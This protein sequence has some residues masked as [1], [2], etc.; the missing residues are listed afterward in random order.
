MKDI[1]RL[2]IKAKKIYVP[3]KEKLI[4]VMIGY[5]KK[6]NIS[7]MIDNG[8]K[9]QTRYI[10]FDCDT[11]EEAIT[12]VEQIVNEYPNDKDTGMADF[13]RDINASFD[14]GGL[15]V[16]DRRNEGYD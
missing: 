15:L 7:C 10:E 3:Q 4:Y 14:Y 16:I 2:I 12:K 6:N 9:G 11:R 1:K 13:D 5:G 8:I